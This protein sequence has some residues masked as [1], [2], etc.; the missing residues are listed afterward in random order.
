[1]KPPKWRLPATPNPT[2]VEGVAQPRKKPMD[3]RAFLLAAAS[4]ASLDKASAHALEGKAMHRPINPTGHTYAQA[5]EVSPGARLLFVSG[6]VPDDETGQT[7]ADIH[8]QCRLVYANIERQL[9]AADMTLSNL[10]KLTVFL[11]DR[12]YRGAHAEVRKAVLGALSPAMT[13]IITGIYDE[14]W[15]LEIEAVAAA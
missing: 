11:S 9:M 3:R 1:V 12:Q 6:Q 14:K 7:P 10:V 4:T 15:L 2:K 8:A 5:H 13:I